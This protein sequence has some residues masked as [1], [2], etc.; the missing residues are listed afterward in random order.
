M[1]IG[2]VVD[3]LL[4][5]GVVSVEIVCQVMEVLDIIF[6][7]VLDIFQV[8]EVLFCE[9]GCIKVLLKGK[10]IV[11]MSFIF[12]IEIKCF[13]CQVNELGGDYFDVL[14]FG[15]EI[16]VCEGMLLIMVG[17][18]EVVFECVKLLFELFGKNIIFV[19][20]NGDG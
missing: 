5:L 3:E 7:M 19:G 8:E 13:V 4:L 9:N 6:I 10:I 16:G 15:G 2:L 20:G 14:V 18:D 1:I 12:L 11:D 17:G